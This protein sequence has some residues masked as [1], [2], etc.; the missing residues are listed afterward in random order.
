MRAP[1]LFLY[2]VLLNSEY[3]F[4]W[5]ARWCMRRGL[6][7]SQWCQECDAHG[8]VGQ[9]TWAIRKC[10]CSWCMVVTVKSGVATTAGR[11]V[12]LA[13][14]HGR[15]RHASESRR[16]ASD[17]NGIE[18]RHRHT[19][20]SQQ[21]SERLHRAVMRKPAFQQLP[22]SPSMHCCGAKARRRVQP[23]RERLHAG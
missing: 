5:A 4:L 20:G 2:N 18:A 14:A 3:K 23:V 15:R 22:D 7:P 8:Q 1:L 17:G 19:S 9:G 6:G 13:T 11:R 10:G 16:R 21:R 12:M